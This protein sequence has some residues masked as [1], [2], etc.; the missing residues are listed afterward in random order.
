MHRVLRLRA[1]ALF[2]VGGLLLSC[3]GGSDAPGWAAGDTADADDAEAAPVTGQG[4]GDPYYPDDGNRGYDVKHYLVDLDYDRPTQ[5]IAATTTI[6]AR[7]T[8]RLPRFQPRPDRHEG[9]QGAGRRSGR[10]VR[11]HRR[12]RARHQAGQADRQRGRLRHQGDLLGQARARPGRRRCRSGWYDAT[13]PG[14]GFIAGE[15]HSCTLWYPVQR[16]PHRQGDVRAE[17]DC[18]PSV[19]R[20]LERRRAAGRCQRGRGRQRASAPTAGGSTSRRPPT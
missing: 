9:R 4:I 6:T 17:G 3:S 15:P 16:P 8:K 19:R 2:A 13:T 14:A 1:A 20:G 12:A 10:N 5:R 11:A 7:A 18:S